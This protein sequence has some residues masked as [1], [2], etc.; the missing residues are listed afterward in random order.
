MVRIVITKHHEQSGVISGGVLYYEL[1]SA[2]R[3]TGC[4]VRY[5]A[6]IVEKKETLCNVLRVIESVAV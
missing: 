1:E 4:G 3:G 6:P 5:F 2:H